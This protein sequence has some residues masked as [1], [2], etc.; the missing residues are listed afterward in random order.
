[1]TRRH[2]LIRGAA[3]VAVLL[4]SIAAC[5]P[6]VDIVQP[7]P[8]TGGAMFAR[9]VS[10][11]NSLTAGFQSAGINAT[12][13]AVAYPV[14]IAAAVGTPF[15][16]PELALPGCPPPIVN[17]LTRERAG[18]GTG[19]S[20][21]LRAPG[22]ITDAINHV[23]VFGATSLDPTSRSTPASNATTLLILG[24][25]SQVER[26]LDADP[27]FVSIWI[28]NNDALDAATTGFV[29]EVAGISRG[30]TTQP[31]FESNYDAMLMELTA[32]TDL[33]GGLLI[34]VLNVT[35]APLLVPAAALVTDAQFKA[36]F[37]QL[38]GT[39]TALL[40]SCSAATTSLISLTI[41]DRI[42]SGTHPPT[43]GCEPEPFPLAPVGDVFVVDAAEQ[44]TIADAVAGYNAYIAARAEA[45]G[46]AY[47]DPNPLLASLR[48]GGQI[49]PVPNLAS[50]TAP[51][52][53]YISLDGVHP[54]AKGQ[55]VIA[56]AALD[57]INQ[58]YGLSIPDVPI[59]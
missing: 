31:T 9:Y 42:R 41:V 13:Q 57:A 25:E 14:L 11:G 38:A 43:I 28:G 12:T 10:L 50:A 21:A 53:D 59:P 55:A 27:S 26:A 51:F 6:D 36:T 22:S 20:C 32:G 49:P 1:V 47:L 16:I 29:V 18:G 5:E 3:A 30:V 19:N 52:G 23:A 45:L 8:P 56:N 46:F 4:A 2:Q 24:G 34:G 35:L 40:P 15:R 44:Q 39:V 17:F 54:S 33:E 37:D 7:P 48:Q 58:E